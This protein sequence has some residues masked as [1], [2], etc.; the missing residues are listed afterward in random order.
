MTFIY[1][2]LDDSKAPRLRAY[3][4]AVCDP[5][6]TAALGDDVLV[7]AADSGGTFIATLLAFTADGGANLRTFSGDYIHLRGGEASFTPIVARLSRSTVRELLAGG[8]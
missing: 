3:E 2:A 8:A 5:D 1:R 6:K 4:A 7:A